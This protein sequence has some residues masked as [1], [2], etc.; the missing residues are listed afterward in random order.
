MCRP[1]EDGVDGGLGGIA[2]IVSPVGTEL[3]TQVTVQ[4]CAV[5][6]LAVCLQGCD[7]KDQEK[8]RQNA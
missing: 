7:R 6:T 3:V 1:P 4:L 8:S 5:Q 2:S